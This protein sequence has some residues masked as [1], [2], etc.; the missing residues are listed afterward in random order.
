MSEECCLP[1]HGIREARA[2]A[3]RVVDSSLKLLVALALEEVAAL[4][5]QQRQVSRRGGAA[6]VVA[7]HAPGSRPRVPAVRRVRPRRV[8]GGGRVLGELQRWAESTA[9]RSV[10]D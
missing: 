1:Q 6:A 7:L 3:R 5:P 8:A 2:G 9:R 10:L 4:E